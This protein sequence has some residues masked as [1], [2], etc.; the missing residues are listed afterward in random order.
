MPMKSSIRGICRQFSKA[1]FQIDLHIQLKDDYGLKHFE[2]DV[3][4]HK[5]IFTGSRKLFLFCSH[6][7]EGD[8]GIIKFSIP[9][10]EEGWVVVSEEEIDHVDSDLLNSSLES[11]KKQW[12]KIQDRITYKGP[13]EDVVRNSLR[14]IRLLTYSE[15]GG[16]IAG[17]TTS[18]PEVLGGERN[19]DYRYVWL[20]DAAMIVSALTRAGS[21]G[22][23]ERKFLS[24]L[25]DA[26]RQNNQESLVPFYALDKT[27]AKKESYLDLA[28]YHNSQPVR[29]GNDAKDQ[30]Q[31]DANANV[32]LAAKL[33]YNRFE[34]KDHW[35]TVR[36]IAD[37]LVDNWQK[38]DHGIWEEDIRQQFTSSKVISSVALKYIAEHAESKKQAERWL[39]ASEDI[40]DYVHKNCLNE[41]GAFAVY[42]GSKHVDITAALYPVWGFI[43]ADAPEML[44]TIEMLDKEYKD[45]ELYRRRLELSDSSEEGVFLAAS[46][47]MAQYFILR[48]DLKRCERIFNAVL[49]F[50]TDLGFLPEEGDIKTGAML[51]NIPQTFV[52][53]SFIGAIIDY[54]DA[55]VK[56]E[57]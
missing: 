15:N 4:D 1:P 53:A 9:K 54:K 42:P 48:G 55:I 37:F 44:K 46:L 33:I 30:L 39:K 32:L 20:R 25:C 13:Y 43:E 17:A 18:I 21:D 38:P 49:D 23:E 2:V 16:I 52:H 34:E 7:I 40:K 26:K 6:N 19:Y 29:I 5:A 11:T 12:I 36:D 10:N 22:V 45:G 41:D 24:F 3:K 28:G 8:G 31:H 47:W 14:A 50:S 51:G 56:S 57:S 27:I 35:E